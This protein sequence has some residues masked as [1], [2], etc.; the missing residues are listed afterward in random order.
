MNT[1]LWTGQIYLTILC[2]FSGTSKSLFSEKKLVQEM[3]QTGVEGL[4][5]SLIRFIG[6]CQLLAAVGLIIPWLINVLL[7]ITPVAAFALGIDIT[8][9]S[10]IHIQRKEYKTASVTL[11]TSLICF[12]VAAGRFHFLSIV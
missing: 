5:A 3:K 4:P 12:F 1:I 10:G 9:A 11:F 8:M 6:I 7:F 2:L